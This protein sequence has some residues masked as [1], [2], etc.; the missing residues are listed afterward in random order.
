MLGMKTKTR[1]RIQ[2]LIGTLIGS[3]VAYY[4]LGH[5]LRELAHY[6]TRH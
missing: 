2:V 3:S 4:W 5:Y 1:Y 6:L